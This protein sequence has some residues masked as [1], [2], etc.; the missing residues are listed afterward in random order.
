M[1]T[2]ENKNL[3]RTG[4]IVFDGNSLGTGNATPSNTTGW[5]L[6]LI[7]LLDI[8]GN[9]R[10]PNWN[11]ICIGGQAT[12][13]M[14]S[15]QAA[16]LFPLYSN[17]RAFNIVIAM[18]VRNDLVFGA[19]T[20]DAY[21]HMVT[22]CQNAKN[23]GFYVIGVNH[24]PSQGGSPVGRTQAQLETARQTVRS[25]FLTDFN[26][27]TNYSLVFKPANGIT[28]ANLWV[29]VG[30]DAVMGDWNNCTDVSLYSDTTHTTTTGATNIATIMARGI[31][32]A[33]DSFT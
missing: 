31:K 3:N 21:N 19:S 18:E 27:A 4:L 22:Y 26:V 24:T 32:C 1:F 29:D 17:T 10:C 20:T 8:N 25:S 7:K 14:T 11:M 30:G 9:F 2:A 33:M 15:Q 5:Q 28:Y 12:T 23:N 13:A 6:Q 16:N